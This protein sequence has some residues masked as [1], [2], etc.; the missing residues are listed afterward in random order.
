MCPVIKKL[1][2]YSQIKTVV[3]LTGQ[4]REMLLPILNI[5]QVAPKYDLNIMKDRQ[6]LFD[7]TIAV[8]SKIK[9]VLDQE[10][11]TVVLVHGDTTSAFA[12]AV[13]CFYKGIPIGHV[14]AGLRT[15]NHYSPY[16]EEFNRQAID[17]ITDI[18][19][20]P[21]VSAKENLLKEGKYEKNIFVT[22]NTVIDALKTTIHAEYSHEVLKWAENNRLIL[23]TAHRRENIGTSMRKIFE[24][25]NEV[26]DEFED[27][28]VVY[29]VHL[30]PKVQEI[31]NEIF[32]NTEKIKLIAPLD[33]IDF[34]NIMSRSYMV[35]TDSGGVQEEAP[36]LGKPV[37]V[38]R[39]TTERPEGVAAGTLKLV[40]TEK[41]N[42]KKALK[43]LLTNK[44]TY[45]KMSEAKNPY[46]D[47]KAS[48]RI[49]QVILKRWGE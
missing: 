28:R 13:A 10:K 32:N 36:S 11:P 22:G 1:E 3:C 21:T 17:S 19:F 23:F 16:P 29:P 18:F 49:G 9:D 5:F 42:I 25:V 15:Y 31:A 7:I 47:G 43:E 34:H 37:L 24:A 41:D 8:L 35:I 14:E 4:H 12:A 27:V 6:T 38:I 44:E 40:G 46:G 33:V 48:E 2:E 45:R 26:V 20:A 30:N 39:N